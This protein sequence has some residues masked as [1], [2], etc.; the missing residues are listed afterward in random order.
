[1][2][3]TGIQMLPGLLW[4][5]LHLHSFLRRFTWPASLHPQRNYKDTPPSPTRDNG[6]DRVP[7]IHP[8]PVHCGDIHS[9]SC[10]QA[11]SPE[12]A[13]NWLQGVSWLAGC[14]AYSFSWDSSQR[15]GKNRSPEGPE[16]MKIPQG[17][18]RLWGCGLR[19]RRAILVVLLDTALSAEVAA[20]V[21]REGSSPEDSDRR[22]K[23]DPTRGECDR[24]H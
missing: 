17:S 23:S 7:Q 20:M 16:N 1:M 9:R 19:L 4:H 14:S 18:H 21:G 12:A 8:G 15:A 5:A 6:R 11:G 3:G 22:R 24:S 10:S 2:T 13:E